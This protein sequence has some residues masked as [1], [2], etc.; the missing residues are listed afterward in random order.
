MTVG[1]AA[2]PSLTIVPLAIRQAESIADRLG[3]GGL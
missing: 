1:G 2:N 3:K